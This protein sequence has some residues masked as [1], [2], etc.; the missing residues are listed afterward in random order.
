MIA[1][2]DSG[3]GG[4]TVLQEALRLIPNKRYIYYADVLN[5]P[6]G[7]KSKDQVRKYVSDAVRFI[8]AK[9]VEALVVACNTATSV[10]IDFLRKEYPFPILGMEPAIKP[11]VEVAKA[12]RIMVFATNLT[13]KETKFRGL[14]NRV[15]KDG[16]I[17]VI[18]LSGLVRFAENMEFERAK[19]EEYLRNGRV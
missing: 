4:L 14:V 9:Q 8:A 19:I 3:I 12:K 2:F 15:D 13:L 11:A 18:P 5:A 6:Y 7:V 17:D 1:F 10:A 16:I